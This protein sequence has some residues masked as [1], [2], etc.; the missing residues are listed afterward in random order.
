MGYPTTLTING[1][2]RTIELTIYESR[3]STF[4]ANVWI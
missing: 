2:K 4:F 1:V 3:F